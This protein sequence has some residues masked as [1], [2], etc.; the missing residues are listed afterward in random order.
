MEKDSEQQS[1][2]QIDPLTTIRYADGPRVFGYRPT[3]LAEQIK[4]GAI[5][6]PKYLGD[7]PSRAKGW[8]GDQIINWRHTLDAK[9]AERAVA[10]K[11]VYDAKLKPGQRKDAK[12]PA[13]KVKKRRLRRPVKT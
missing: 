2:L 13:A 7:P 11:K 5:P 6:A 10:A 3:Q 4:A 8:T 9:Q 12:A 1:E